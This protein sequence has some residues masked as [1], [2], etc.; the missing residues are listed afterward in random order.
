MIKTHTHT[1]TYNW[2]TCGRDLFPDSTAFRRGG[3]RV[4][5]GRRREGRKKEKCSI[6]SNGNRGYINLLLDIIYAIIYHDGLSRRLCNADTQTAWDYSAEGIYRYILGGRCGERESR[7]F[8]SRTWRSLSL[9]PFFFLLCGS[10]MEFTVSPF[11]DC[12][13]YELCCNDY[14]IRHVSTRS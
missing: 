6:T 7:A 4:E 14:L 3:E 5:R 13:C 8:L 2:K 9:S 12:L 1:H 11:T 10:K